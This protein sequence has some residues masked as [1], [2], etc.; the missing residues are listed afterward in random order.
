MQKNFKP[1]P[2]SFKNTFCVFHEVL[3]NEI[4]GLKKQFE[5]KAG[6]TYYYTEAG[7]YRVSN[8]WGRLANSK[9]RLIARDV[10]PEA[11]GESKTKIG[12]AA[13][14]EFYA[15]NA[16]EKLYYIEADFEK[17][18]VTYQH[19]KN[20]NYDSKAILRTSFE[21]TKRIKQIRNL[22]QLTSWAKHFDY[23]DIADLR[24]KII[25]ELI[26]TEKTLEEIKRQI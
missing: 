4:E 10:D 22:Q 21:T 14:N 20:P 11:S 15:D 25:T 12:F 3:A 26:F 1:H 7:M 17:N 8:H 5:S 24:K 13:W 6:S 9:W 16:E 19:K 18:T 23:D 2:N